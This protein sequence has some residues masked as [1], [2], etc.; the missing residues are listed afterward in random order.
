MSRPSPLGSMTDEDLAK[1]TFN[2]QTEQMLRD[3]QDRHYPG[4]E[5]SFERKRRLAQGRQMAE[6]HSLPARGALA[7]A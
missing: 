2:P 5:L 6:L 4:L 3:S 1:L 7:T